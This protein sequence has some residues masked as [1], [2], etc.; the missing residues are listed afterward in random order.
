MT[1]RVGLTVRFGGMLTALAWLGW[2]SPAAGQAAAEETGDPDGPGD[3]AV[4]GGAG[5]SE[6]P[7]AAG[8]EPVDVVVTGK[9]KCE[10]PFEADRAVSVVGPKQLREHQPRTTPEALSDVPGVFVQQTNHGG[11]SPIVH[12]LIG[13]QVLLL[14]DGVRLN[15]STYR[16]G[17]LQYLNLVDPLSLARIEVLRGPGSVLYGSDAMGGVIQLFPHEP[18]DSRMMQSPE[19][20]V[21]QGVRYASSGKSVGAHA[22]ADLGVEGLGVMAHGTLQS[23][24]DLRGGGD[25]GRQPY[26]GYDDYTGLVTLDYR[27]GKGDLDGW[28]NKATYLVSRVDG[29]GRTDKLYDKQSLQIYDNE[30]HLVY[31]RSRLQIDAIK[32]VLE[33]TPS[34]Q[35][36][37]ER[38]DAIRMGEDLTTR[39]GAVRDEVIVNTI[40]LDG[41]LETTFVD[42]RL[43]LRYGGLFYRDW[44]DARRL[45]HDT[46]EP[47]MLRRDQA[48]PS[49]STY[50]HYGLFALL[51]GAVLKTKG[52][53]QVNLRSGYRLHGMAGAADAQANLP[54]VELS[55]VGHVFMGAVQYLYEDTA[56]VAFAFAQG[57][58]AP[59]LQEAVQLGDTGKFFHVPNDELGPEK[60]DTVELLGRLRMWKLTVSWASY[61]SMLDDLILRVPTTYEGQDEIDGKAVMHNVN[62]EG[63]LV[64]GTEGGLGVDMGHGF[65]AHGQMSYAWGAQYESDGAT[66]PLRRIPPL[67][68]TTS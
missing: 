56:T 13:P 64:M 19:L 2:A 8:A 28:R 41:Q 40:G 5:Q 68:G 37:F 66:E 63:G 35:H 42:D 51:E 27:F 30:L 12:G 21:T 6:A 58:R 36:F 4:D 59:N 23:L 11:G 53:H 43:A 31:D 44:V 46:D 22:R 34:F 15:N 14:F 62:A 38:K 33:L 45:E 67:S 17:P 55:H 50:D 32:T 52:G 29:A 3:A 9:R 18:Q 10:D 39:L 26:S 48:Y 47:W 60:T 20:H 57:F 16:T 61:L 1:M 24:G 49:G 54:A 65:S 7:A 25:V